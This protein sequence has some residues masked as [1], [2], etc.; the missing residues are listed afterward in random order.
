MQ[1]S[2]A[3]GQAAFPH[4]RR[5]VRSTDLSAAGPARA[6]SVVLVVFAF[7]GAAFAV[8]SVAAGA[9][10]VVVLDGGTVEQRPWNSAFAL[11]SWSALPR[12]AWVILYRREAAFSILSGMPSLRS[13]SMRAANVTHAGSALVSAVG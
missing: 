2:L 6:Y 5:P 9:S 11:V 10:A 7:L 8:F 1:A 3:E 12:S 4:R 13:A